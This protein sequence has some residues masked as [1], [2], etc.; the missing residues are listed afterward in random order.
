M[1][2]DYKF[3]EAKEYDDFGFIIFLVSKTV[4]YGKCS[5]DVSE[6]T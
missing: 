3:Y 2:L 6:I 4:A 1:P 5:I